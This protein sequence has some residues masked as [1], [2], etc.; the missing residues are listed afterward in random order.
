MTVSKYD[1]DNILKTLPIGYY[2]NRNVDVKLT[3]EQSSYYDMMNDMVH[4]S[5]PM[6]A[7]VV[8]NVDMLEKDIRCLLY[9]EISHAF[10]TPKS[11][12]ATDVVNIFEDERI[13]SVLRYY[14]RDVNFREFVIRYNNF[15]GQPPKNAMDMFYQVVRFRVGPKQ[16]VDEVHIIIDKYRELNRASEDTY[17]YTSS[18]VNLYE[19][20]K[21]YWNEDSEQSSENNAGNSQSQMPSTNAQ[22]TDENTQRNAENSTD[23]FANQISQEQLEEYNQREF[24]ENIAKRTIQSVVDRFED[25]DVDA[26]VNRILS[27]VKRVNKANSTAINAY[28]GIFNPRSVIRDDYKYFVQQNRAGHVKAFAKIHLNL[29]I[30]SSGSFRNNDLTTNKLLKALVKFEKSNPNFSFDLISC[31][32]GQKLRDK[33]DRIQTSS[34][35]N[36]LSHS[37]YDLYR[38]QQFRDAENVNIVL[39]DGDAFSDIGIPCKDEIKRFEV[40]NNKNTI[41]ISDDEN[42]RYITRYCKNTKVIITKSYTQELYKHV[43]FALQA[44]CK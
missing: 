17:M 11:M 29:F 18:I 25:S 41:L 43:L 26:D 22:N 2:I 35:C 19:K 12:M 4:I 13:E 38:Q 42:E 3:D 34:G 20:I 32:I 1:V 24:N 7:K 23:K 27:S 28:S 9:H 37:I 40:F 39:F 36:Y 16:F 8:N 14:Y 5:Y 33:H 30:D 21:D 10:L 44:L 6:I 15:K 31:G